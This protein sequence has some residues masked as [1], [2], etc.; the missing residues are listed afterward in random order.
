MLVGLVVLV[1]AAQNIPLARH[2]RGVERDRLI[3]AL[4]RDA[5]TLAGRSAT[6]LDGD[7]AAE[8]PAVARMVSEYRGSSEA[9]VVVTDENGIA[10]VSSDE[11]SIAG[12]DYGTRPEIAAAL[13][14][15]PVSGERHSDTL[16]TDLVYV[17]VPV[18]AGDDVIGAVRIT[19]PAGVIED[20]VDDRVRSLTVV[21]AITVADGGDRGPRRRGERDPAAALAAAHDRAAGGRRP[22]GAGRDHGW[23]AGGARPGRS[24]S[25][26]CRSGRS[27][28]STSSASSP[29]TRRTSCGRRSPRCACASSRPASCSRPTRPAPAPGSSRRARRPN[30]CS[31]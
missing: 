23:S 1:L 27:S 24:R 2:L 22:H 9:R 18:L 28:S 3:T 26:G 8:D 29:V 21:A 10:V 5:F 12:Q 7:R 20:R 4:E 15:E 30:A 6:A 11:E 14:G 13:G 25:T 16:G 31:T 17:A 19:Y